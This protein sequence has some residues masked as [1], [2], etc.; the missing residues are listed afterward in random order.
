MID[1]NLGN[2]VTQPKGAAGF[3][4]YGSQRSM[5]ACS[6]LAAA[7]AYASIAATLSRLA[8][9]ARAASDWLPPP[10]LTPAAATRAAT[11]AAAVPAA[12]PVQK[13]ADRSAADALARILVFCEGLCSKH[14]SAVSAGMP[15]RGR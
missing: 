12:A 6:L 13:P 5:R 8:C 7:L 3:V 2:G 14:G 9:A 1:I 15:W 4:D 11:A 10:A